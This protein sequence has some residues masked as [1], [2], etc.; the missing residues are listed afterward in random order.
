MDCTSQDQDWWVGTGTVLFPSL[1]LDCWVGT[2]SMRPGSYNT[3]IPCASALGTHSPGI[4]HTLLDNSRT[5][6]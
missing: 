3:A 2:C 5:H 1:V 4:L 6:W